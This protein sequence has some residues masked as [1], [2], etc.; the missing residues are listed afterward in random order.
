MTRLAKEGTPIARKRSH[1]AT[2]GTL[3]RDEGI[4]VFWAVFQAD[5]EGFRSAFAAQNVFFLCSLLG[6]ICNFAVLK[7]TKKEYFAA[8]TLEYVALVNGKLLKSAKV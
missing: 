6:I 2:V 8:V 3:V 7:P 4:A 1:G 5:T